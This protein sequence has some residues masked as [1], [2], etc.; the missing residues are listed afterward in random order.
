[1]NT[2]NLGVSALCNSLLK[3]ISTFKPNAQFSLLIGSKSNGAEMAELKRKK[4]AVKIINYRLSP[5][6]NISEHLL[7]ILTLA[8]IQKIVPIAWIK[9]KIIESN[10]FLK[11]LN[12]SDFIGDI[13]GGDSFSDIYGYERFLTQIIPNLIILLLNKKL[14]LL[15]QT[16]G[17]FNSQFSKVLSGYVM[18]RAV[19]IY[20]RDAVGIKI[21]EEMT[22]INAP[23]AI[24]CPDVAFVLDSIKPV[25]FDNHSPENRI[26][27][28]V[29]GLLYN[30]G[31]SKNN[32]FSLKYEYKDFIIGLCEHFLKNTNETILL[33]P[34]TVTGRGHVE[35]DLT[36]CY[37]VKR[38]LSGTSDL[39]RLQVI[40]EKYRECEIKGVIGTCGFFIGSRMHACIAALSQGIPTVSLAYSRKFQGVFNTIGMEECVIDATKLDSNQSLQLIRKEYG[41]KDEIK[42]DLLRQSQQIEKLIFDRLGENFQT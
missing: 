37:D 13:H 8:L 14:V 41:R 22:G 6:A 12:D 27:I 7:W 42:I 35:D 17:P 39:Q 9:R 4:I 31:Y 20:S 25:E 3:I 21:T 26:G 24:F 28:N 36:A 38:N 30:G 40:E 10:Q 29:S 32:M 5:K 11:T 15:P 1:M 19:K 18:R 2:G 16:Y 33:I 23:Q 34:H